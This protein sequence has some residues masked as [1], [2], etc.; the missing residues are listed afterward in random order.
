MVAQRWYCFVCHRNSNEHPPQVPKLRDYERAIAQI[1]HR[2][3]NCA[4]Q[5]H[6][7]AGLA[8]LVQRKAFNTLSGAATAGAL[9]VGK[10]TIYARRES[11]EA[12]VE[13][14]YKQ[15][16][17]RDFAGIARVKV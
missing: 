8:L 13:A 12:L 6:P 11:M 17:G 4:L 1:V 9:D 5:L 10:L 2:S 15:F 16:S 3:P 7:R 14:A